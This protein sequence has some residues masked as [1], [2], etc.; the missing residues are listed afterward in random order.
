LAVAL[1]VHLQNDGVV[2]ETV[3][4]GERHGGIRKDGCPFAERSVRGDQEAAA[5]VSGSNQLEQHAGLR[6]IPIDVAEI[7][8]NDQVV[9]VELLEGALQRQRLP[10]GLQTLHE[11]GRAGEQHAIAVLDE[12]MTE[13]C[14]EM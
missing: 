12:G 14:P 5:L 2:H 11:V 4:C 8:E 10:G 7:I 13:G 3:N 1:D 9:F 6:L